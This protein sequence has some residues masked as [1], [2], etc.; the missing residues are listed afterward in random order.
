MT[1]AVV[2]A[3]PG[4]ISQGADRAAALSNVQQA[5]ELWLDEWRSRGR[6][7]P[8]ESRTMLL[9]GVEEALEVQQE[10]A[11]EAEREPEFAIEL[12]TVPIGVSLAA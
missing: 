10:V 3:L 11:D 7:L 9:R 5:M 1:T 4:C 8:K 2:P 12:R 6:R